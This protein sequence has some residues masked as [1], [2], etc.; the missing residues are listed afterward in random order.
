MIAKKHL[1]QIFS[2]SNRPNIRL[3]T[4]LYEPMEVLWV[5]AKSK[6]HRHRA[7]SHVF[8]ES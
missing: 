1:R 6:S 8:G 3:K 5:Y 7:R 2:A 4:L